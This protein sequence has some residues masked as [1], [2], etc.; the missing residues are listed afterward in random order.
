MTLRPLR[1]RPALRLR[2]DPWGRLLVAPRARFLPLLLAATRFRRPPRFLVR[3]LLPPPIPFRGRRP[4]PLSPFGRSLQSLRLV[5][6]FYQLL[7]RRRLAALV[8]ML[9]P[10]LPLLSLLETLPI[11]LLVRSLLVRSPFQARQFLA[12]GQVLLEGRPLSPFR[13]VR[14]GQLLCLRIPPDPPQRYRSSSLSPATPPGPPTHLEV[15]PALGA[16]VLLVRP[17]PEQLLWSPALPLSPL[18]AL[19]QR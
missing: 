17:R 3:S 2:E 6:Q 11:P 5:R 1:F 8:P 12:H 10:Q 7:R 9:S 4:R 18:L 19:L 13:L 16:L 15:S 14:P